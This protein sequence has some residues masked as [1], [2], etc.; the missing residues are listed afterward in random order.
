MCYSLPKRG[1]PSKRPLFYD[2]YKRPGAIY[3]LNAEIPKDQLTPT[4]GASL[5]WDINYFSFDFNFISS[6]NL[7][8]S[9]GSDACFVRCVVD[10]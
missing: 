5:G 10:P 4:D 1:S 2:L 9:G 7:I 8:R 3:W 6:D